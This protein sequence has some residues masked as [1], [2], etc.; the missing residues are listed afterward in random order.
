MASWY[1]AAWMGDLI[2]LCTLLKELDATTEKFGFPL[3]LRSDMA[4]EAGFVGQRMWEER[5]PESYIAG[6]STANQ[7]GT[8]ALRQACILLFC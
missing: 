6:R 4:F 8:S 5:G 1:M 3:R 7:V 2:L